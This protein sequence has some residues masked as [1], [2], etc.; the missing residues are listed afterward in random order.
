MRFPTIRDVAR[1][2]KNVHDYSDV[3]CD[4]RLQVSED[5]TWAI[6]HGDASYDLDHRG[7]WGASSVP[8]YGRRFNSRDVARD[9]IDQCRDMLADSQ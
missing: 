7:Y 8:G 1:A 3:E 5:G 4:I 9:L 6:R 2:V